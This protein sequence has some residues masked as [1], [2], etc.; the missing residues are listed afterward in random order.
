M[1]P[2]K[3]KKRERECDCGF[4]DSIDWKDSESDQHVI[5][6][7]KLWIDAKR[8]LNI[9]SLH[10]SIS[11]EDTASNVRYSVKNMEEDVIKKAEEMISLLESLVDDANEEI[12]EAKHKYA[13]SSEEDDE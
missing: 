2:K 5:K 3:T 13:E 10:E 8:D 7:L 12:D 1:D 11:I 4:E 6:R 9:G